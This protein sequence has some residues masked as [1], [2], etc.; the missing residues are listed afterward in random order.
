[1][2][3]KFNYNS[4]G[5]YAIKSHYTFFKNTSVINVKNPT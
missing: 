2:E 1:L 4:L 3:Y 5:M